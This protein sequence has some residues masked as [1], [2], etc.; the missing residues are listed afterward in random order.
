M[1]S[2]LGIVL[3]IV[4]LVIVISFHEFAH[5]WVANRLGDP[6]AKYYGR[7]TLNP[8]AH[9]DFI[10]TIMLF[11][12]H[13][14]WGKPV[15]VNP[16]NFRHPM[17]DSALTALAGP[18]SNLVLAFVAA[19]PYK[20]FSV[21]V[22]V[23]LAAVFFNILFELSVTLAVFNFLPFPPLDGSKILGLIVPRKYARAYESFLQNGMTYFVIFMLAD[24]FFLERTFGFSLI[25]YVVGRITE[26]VK[27]VILLG[28]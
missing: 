27:L 22:D 26:I 4:A 18:G 11:L 21:A 14:G 7:L 13:I 16:E 2:L 10:G 24:V 3:F 17:R 12:I 28:T 23:P 19:L 25:G 9:L 8:F 15:P 5:A 1:D 20:F 6:T